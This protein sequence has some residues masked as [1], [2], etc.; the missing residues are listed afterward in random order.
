ML[1]RPAPWAGFIRHGGAGCCGS[2]A[3][4]GGRI[5][6]RIPPVREIS[7]FTHSFMD[8]CALDAERIDAC[9]FMT[10][11]ASGPML[12]RAYDAERARHLLK[13]IR[14]AEFGV[15]F[16]PPDWTIANSGRVK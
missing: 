12:M 4:R 9:V 7:F 6:P 2:R 3:R 11:T 8:A 1:K 5:G 10:A 13:T 16:T 14:L 15:R